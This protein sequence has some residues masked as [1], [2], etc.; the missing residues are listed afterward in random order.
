[1][2]ILNCSI[3]NKE[4]YAIAES[5]SYFPYASGVASYIKNHYSVENVK[6]TIKKMTLPMKKRLFS[7]TAICILVARAFNR[8][9]SLN[10][11]TK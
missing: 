7:S 5:D 11:N 2:L 3:Q 9:Y 8:L 10:L 4:L 6:I 1:M